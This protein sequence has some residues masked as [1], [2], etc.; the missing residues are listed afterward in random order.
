ML[1][2]ESDMRER[3]QRGCR[4]RRCKKTTV[5]RDAVDGIRHER[6]KE[7]GL[8]LSLTEEAGEEDSCCSRQRER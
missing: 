8:L 2:A 3:K 7:A 1:S 6:K 5:R 4:C